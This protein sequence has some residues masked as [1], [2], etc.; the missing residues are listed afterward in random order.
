MTGS[1]RDVEAKDKYC[2]EQGI[3]DCKGRFDGLTGLT[4]GWLDRRLVGQLC[5]FNGIIVG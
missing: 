1:R 3:H 5:G 2:S 4:V